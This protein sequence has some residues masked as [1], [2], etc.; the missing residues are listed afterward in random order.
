MADDK[1]V[2]RR[3]CLQLVGASPLLS[4]GVQSSFAPDLLAPGGTV[5]WQVTP[6]TNDEVG[7]PRATSDSVYVDGTDVFALSPSDGSIQW[8]F[9]DTEG[10]AEVDAHDG[11]TVYVD[12]ARHVHAIDAMSGVEQ[13]RFEMGNLPVVVGET[14]YLHDH[15]GLHAVASDG[16]E[17]WSFHTGPEP[18]REPQPVPDAVVTGSNRGSLY[19][20]SAADGTL[21][22]KFDVGGDSLVHPVTQP[23]PAER[24]EPLLAWD[25]GKGTLYGIDIRNG[26]ER[27]RY[28]HS[29]TPAILPGVVVNDNVYV[30][31]DTDVVAVSKTDGTTRWRSESFEASLTMPRSDDDT[32]FAAGSNTVYSFSHSTGST[33]WKTELGNETITRLFEVSSLGLPVQTKKNSLYVLSPSTGNVRWKY[34]FDNRLAWFPATAGGTLYAGT[35]SGTVYALVE[36][37]RTAQT[38]TRTMLMNSPLQSLG[39]GVL[40]TAI[41]TGTYC[42]FGADSPVPDDAPSYEAFEVVE[43]LRD[44]DDGVVFAARSPSGERVTLTRFDSD[45]IDSDRFVDAVETWATLDV[46]GVLG[47]R[48]WGT[49]PIP[50]VATEPL[51]APFGDCAD[52]L[53]TADL[54]HAIADVAETI[55]R[56]HRAGVTHGGLSPESIWIADGDVQVA[57]WGLA[58][59]IWEPSDADDST[60]LAAMTRDLLADRQ[61]PEEL[62][63]V[64]SLALADDPDDRYDSLLKFADALRWAVRE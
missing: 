16:T 28:D 22:W 33:R 46:S 62:D 56:A 63:E 45:S 54:A 55:Y 47:V 50:W 31:D 3:D 37:G 30:S 2:S 4:M 52:D 13:W 15:D 38:R 34:E 43:T 48:A 61:V 8:S 32:V 1:F 42:R 64:L 41:L 11:G 7:V 9:T 40:V 5:R 44:T 12:D 6:G 49:D 17:R 27:W 51:D 59:E 10:E 19:A 53:V 57:D 25:D 23:V 18:L 60:Q 58:A 36:P 20:V 26:T 21:R 39:V 29:E 14:T 24:T 35:T